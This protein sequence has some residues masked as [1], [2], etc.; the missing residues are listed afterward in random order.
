MALKTFSAGERLF[1]ADLNDN[2]QEVLESAAGATGGGTDRV[3]F[4]NDTTVTSGYTI[5]SGKNAIT[6]G[7]ITISS[8]VVVTVPSGSEWTV[9]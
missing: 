5:T 3:F 8:G 7:P 4:E 1:A 6:G 9:V 2:F